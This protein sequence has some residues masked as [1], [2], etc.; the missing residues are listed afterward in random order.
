MNSE[1]RRLTQKILE[2][3]D[4]ETSLY[5]YEPGSSKKEPYQG[6]LSILTF[7]TVSPDTS[8]F[9]EFC[10][11]GG[12]PYY[13][14]VWSLQDLLSAGLYLRDSGRV[15]ED[16]IE[17][18]SEQNI[19][20]RYEEFGGIF[21]HVLPPLMQSLNRTYLEK[22]KAIAK[23]V[24][25]DILNIGDIEND[26]VSHYILQYDVQTSGNRPFA[27]KGAQFA[28]PRTAE[29]LQSKILSVSIRTKITTLMKND[30][31]GY[32]NDVCPQIY[33]SVVGQILTM[34]QNII[35]ERKSFPDG[36][37]EEASMKFREHVSGRVPKFDEL[38]EGVL[39]TS[40][41]TNFP[42][43]DHILK[44]E[45]VVFG[46]QVTRNTSLKR[47]VKEKTWDKLFEQLGIKPSQFRFILCPSPHLVNDYQIRLRDLPFD[48]E[49]W[50]LPKDYGLSQ[51]Q[52]YP[53]IAIES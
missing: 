44:K 48:V 14:P 51:L 10:K 36:S 39:Y 38:E 35:F 47:D 1:L 23:A 49:I 41:N 26:E 45:G 7:S 33:E 34:P 11:T 8:R 40:L 6:G 50:K 52:L 20:E 18:Y 21:R 4:P 27:F 29:Q 28:S 37:W 53:K 43:V 13:M 25:Y 3:F 15:P 2:C 24:G 16:M 19:Q 12:I 32:C 9:K 17:F 22:K 31:T 5:L 30:E 42:V 46:I